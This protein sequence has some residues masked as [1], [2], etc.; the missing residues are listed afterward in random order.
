ML[1]AV[2]IHVVTQSGVAEVVEQ[3]VEVSLHHALHVG[4]VVVEV[5]HAIPV[6]ARVILVA[7]TQLRTLADSPVVG[8]TTIIVVADVGRIHAVGRALVCLY[9]E[10]GPAGEGIAVVDDHIG[11]GA[12]ALALEGL[13]HRAQLG[14][15]AKRAVV[16]AEPVKVVVAH[17]TSAAAVGALRYPYQTEVGCEVIGL[18]FEVEPL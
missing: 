18:G 4:T 2:F 17:G 6:V 16:I 12:N 10:V 5:A 13:D 9:R 8:A 11:N 3:H 15:V 7:E 1:S 14:L